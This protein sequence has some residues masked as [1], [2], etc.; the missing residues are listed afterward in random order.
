MR[1]YREDV[2]GDPPYTAAQAFAAGLVYARCLRDAGDASETA[3]QAAAQQLACTTLYGAFHLDPASGLQTGHQV[4]IVQWQ[5]GQ[6]RVV[7]PPEQAEGP[8]R[9]PL[10]TI[11]P[12]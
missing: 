5:Q 11:A 10:K 3:M 8:L 9:F 4:V 12:L 6:R 1:R 2:G 7:W